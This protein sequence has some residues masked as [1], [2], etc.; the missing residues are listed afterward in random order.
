MVQLASAGGLLALL[1]EDQEALQVHG[2]KGLLRCVD[3]HWAEVSS[4]VSRI[5][6]FYEDDAFPERKLA[7]LI[8]SK[9]RRRIPGTRSCNS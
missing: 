4:A 8:A 1:E 6:T 7:A 9:V 3:D 2:L 5:E